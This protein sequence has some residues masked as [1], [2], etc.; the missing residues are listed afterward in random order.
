[1]MAVK[2]GR[3]IW[4]FVRLIGLALILMLLVPLGLTLVYGV[5][6]PVST[7]MLWR[8]VTGQ[9]VQRIWVPLDAVSPALIRAVIVAEDSRYCQHRGVDV[10]GVVDAFEETDDLRRARGGSSITQQ[11]VKNLFLWPSR[12]YVRKVIEVPLA[13]WLDL[14]LGKRRVLEI[15]LNVVEWGPAGQFGVEA[16]ARRAFGKSAAALDPREASLLVTM[17]PNPHTRDARRPGPGLLRLA[18]VYERRAIAWTNTAACV[19]R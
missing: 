11:A 2:R 7:V 5:V 14:I 18:G 3:G 4:R 12:S 15:Y 6:A 9:P 19:L 1:M 10:R 17:L 13:V 16:G 8:R